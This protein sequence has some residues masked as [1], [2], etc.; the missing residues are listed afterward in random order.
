[1]AFDPI[2]S[3]NFVLC[4]VIFVLGVWGYRKKGDAI[5]IYIGLAFGIFGLTHLLTL[6]GFR[7]ILTNV[8]IVIR[9][10]AYLLVIFALYK[11]WKR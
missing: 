4:A 10:I 3:L 11:Y 5:P 9:T 8:F 2:Y 7:T 6:L 1:M